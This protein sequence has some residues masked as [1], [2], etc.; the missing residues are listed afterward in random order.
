V[1]I[2]SPIV[3]GFHDFVDARKKG[4]GAGAPAVPVAAGPVRQSA[5]KPGFGPGA[6]KSPVKVAK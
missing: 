1:Y 3:L 5:S 6:G 2:A 4:S